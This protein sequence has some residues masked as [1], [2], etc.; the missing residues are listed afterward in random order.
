MEEKEI[1]KP[2]P[3]F[4]GYFASNLGKIK[5]RK[6]MSNGEI[7]ERVLCPRKYLGYLQIGIYQGVNR[8]YVQVHRLVA[9]AFLGKSDMV[10]DHI[11][12]IRD[13]NRIENLR[14]VTQ[15]ENRIN[16]ESMPNETIR[17]IM[18]GTDFYQDFQTKTAASKA[19]GR[20]DKFISHLCSRAPESIYNEG[21]LI[22]DGI[23]VKIIRHEKEEK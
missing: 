5:S 10:V 23:R 9:S 22:V 6:R 2:I 16:S 11:N 15:S 19:L 14:Y 4:S 1:W 17:L 21:R 18:E 12:R 8:K 13:D 3:D 20:D 7:F